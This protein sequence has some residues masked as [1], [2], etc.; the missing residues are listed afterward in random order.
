MPSAYWPASRLPAKRSN[1][2][3]LVIH[4]VHR[5]GAGL[6]FRVVVR[7]GALERASNEPARTSLGFHPR[8]LLDLERLL[9]PARQNSK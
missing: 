3:Q 6:G 2:G 4:L 5:A 7:P 8:G 9:E 1:L